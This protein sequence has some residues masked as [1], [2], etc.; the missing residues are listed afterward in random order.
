MRKAEHRALMKEGDETLK[1]NKFDWLRNFLDLRREPSFQSLYNANLETSKA[2]R[3]K[4]S[5]LGFWDYIYEGSAVK[6]FKAWCKQVNRSNLE[7]VK[8]VSRMLEN[9]LQGLLNYLKHRITNAA[10]EG[11]NSLV[12]RMIANARGLRTFSALRIRVLFF[13]GKLDLSIA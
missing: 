3:L 7:P 13:L 9:R 8:K 5:F 11:M 4:E 1:N 2:W 6:F 10:S 12:A